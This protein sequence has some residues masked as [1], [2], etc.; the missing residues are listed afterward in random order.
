MT[1][2]RDWWRGVSFERVPLKQ[3]VTIGEKIGRVLHSDMEFLTIAA[4]G[5]S[6]YELQELAKGWSETAAWQEASLTM[7]WSPER[8][9]GRRF[10]CP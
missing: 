5:G 2:H 6:E 4:A 7:C 8:V 3:L 10:G 9:A 1:E